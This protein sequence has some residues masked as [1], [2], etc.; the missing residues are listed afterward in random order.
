MKAAEDQERKD[1]SLRRR[2]LQRRA[3]ALA[4]NGDQTSAK[5]LKRLKQCEDT[6]RVFDRCRDA[7]GLVAGGG[8]SS[9]Q[10]PSDPSVHPKQATHWR[11]VDVPQEVE[12]L[13]LERNRA[14]FGQA[15]G[16]PWTVPPLSQEIDF[17]ASSAITDLILNG[18]Y[19]H[20]DLDEITQMLISHLKRS[21]QPAVEGRITLEEF[22]TKMVEWK[23]KT[24]TS[25]SGVHLGHYKSY[26][27]PVLLDNDTPEGIAFQKIR[28]DM[29]EAQLYLLNFAIEHGH[30]YSRWQKIVTMMIEK[31][32]GN[33]KIHRLGVIH[34]YEADYNLM[35]CVKWRQALHHA[36]S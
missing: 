32:K 18:T 12:R 11:T 34:I 23:E 5:Y 3:D 27:A 10:V 1:F 35:L 20:A 29:L 26:F 15:Q 6:A 2:F 7:R 31:E 8:F 30:S 19:T 25:P 17:E 16:T 36:S 22:K 9:I 33:H 28:T 21:T 13:L 24:S 14:H 4:L